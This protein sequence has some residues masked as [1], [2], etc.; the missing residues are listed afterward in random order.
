MWPSVPM[1]TCLVPTPFP[2][3]IAA[4]PQPTPA[5]SPL[6]PALAILRSADADLPDPQA[7][8]QHRTARFRLFGQRGPYSD[9]SDPRGVERIAAPPALRLL[10]VGAT[11]T[12]FDN[13]PSG[14]GG[15]DDP[16]N[17]TAWVG[18]TLSAVAA[19]SAAACSATPTPEPPG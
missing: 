11:Q 14:G 5:D 19:W 2:R 8:D 15:P 16:A 10:T 18:G 7:G 17:P 6:Q 9:W 1:A 4:T 12:P 3:F 13:S